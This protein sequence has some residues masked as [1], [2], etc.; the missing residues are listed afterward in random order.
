[1]HTK[2][3]MRTLLRDAQS[4]M[5]RHKRP[6]DAGAEDKGAD[7]DCREEKE[8]K[9]G[10]DGRRGSVERGIEVGAPIF[11]GRLLSFFPPAFRSNGAQISE[12][13]REGGRTKPVPKSWTAARQPINSSEKSSEKA[14][15]SGQYKLYFG[16][17]HHD[18]AVPLSS[19]E[20]ENW[21]S[22]LL[23]Y[24][25][26]ASATGDRAARASNAPQYK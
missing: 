16:V 5:G 15:L 8:E 26:N 1:M 3:T 21:I 12:G 20:S 25:L 6:T 19:Y 4:P 18:A 23:H 17:G 7:A 2:R 13:G 22:F 10:R 11:S 14:T 24:S 9:E